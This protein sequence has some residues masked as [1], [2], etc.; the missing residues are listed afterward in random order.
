MSPSSISLFL[1]LSLFLYFVITN[2]YLLLYNY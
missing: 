2:Y 1:F